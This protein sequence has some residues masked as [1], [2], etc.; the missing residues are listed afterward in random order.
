[1]VDSSCFSSEKRKKSL[2]ALIFIPL[3]DNPFFIMKKTPV[4]GK[5]F[6]YENKD[7]EI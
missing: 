7:G 1:M 4:L 5:I 2:S 6:G 3:N